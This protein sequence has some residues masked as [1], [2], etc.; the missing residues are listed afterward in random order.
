MLKPSF[1]YG[2]TSET[3]HRARTLRKE[4][5]SSEKL[6]WQ[7]LRRN[8]VKGFYFRRQHPIGRYI[9]DF[10]CHNAKLVI[11]LDGDVHDSEEAKERD[12][13]RTAVIE[14]YGI[15]VI[16]FSNGDVFKNTQFVVEEIEKYLH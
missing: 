8:N 12:A 13:N 7:V 5:T 6:M 2:A 16:R 10:Y 4:M 9:A 15:K 14:K 11:E 1:Y 3:F